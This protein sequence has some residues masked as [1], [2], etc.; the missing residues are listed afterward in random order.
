M[1][2]LVE[3][4]SLYAGGVTRVVVE[5]DPSGPDGRVARAASG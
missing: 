4:A 2:N 1:A 5:R 3:N